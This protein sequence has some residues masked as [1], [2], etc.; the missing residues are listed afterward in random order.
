MF[1]PERPPP[2]DTV[3]YGEDWATELCNSVKV[4]RSTGSRTSMVIL[5]EGAIDRNLAAIKADAVK[6]VLEDRLG[7]DTRVTTLGHVQRG[8]SP[9]FFDR[10][11]GTVQGAE[12]IASILRSTPGTPAPMI[13]MRNNVIVSVQLMEAV[14]LTQSV[15]EAIGQKDFKKAMD[16]RDPDFHYSFDTYIECSSMD[17]G[18]KVP[19][20]DQIRV[21]II[22]IG[23]P[24]SGMNAA[25]R[26]ATRLCISR[27]HVPIAIRNG[28]TGLINDEVREISWGEVLDWQTKGGSELGC[29][30]AHPKPLPGS[31]L[32]GGLKGVDKYV[33]MGQIAYRLQKHNIQALL[34]I[35]G[36]EAYTSVI[37][38]TS[39][40]ERYPAFC[41]PMVVIPATVSNNVPG[42][43]YSIGS[44][45]ALNVIVESCDIIKL[46]ANASRKRYDSFRNLYFSVFV[47]EVQGGNCG[48]LATL[49]GLTA[50]SIVVYTHE[51]GISLS[52]LSQ[53]VEFLKYRY[54]KE[55]EH[56]IPNEGRLIV[57]ADMP[58][59]ANGLAFGTETIC[60]I[61]V[62]EANG[63]FDARSAI[64]GHL[65][66]GRIPSPCNINL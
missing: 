8:G 47:V 12:A 57:R 48:Y 31:K 62:S 24:S 45:T 18:T 25:T 56:G 49:G 40:R 44:D 4:S 5:C 1:L 28:F 32:D 21:G 14:K 35:G 43:E 3:K 2:Q 19:V 39:G 33:E 38:L 9:C 16:L 27:G 15:A 63:L 65:Q 53:D 41:I 66:Q 59:G 50:G 42:T 6:K 51:S 37:T 13:G 26:I 11:M 46:S 36:F 7:L 55:D 64:L 23:A 29:N 60:D 61:L 58:V 52:K 54:R 30:R 34:V 20:S 22:H 10:Y 17:T